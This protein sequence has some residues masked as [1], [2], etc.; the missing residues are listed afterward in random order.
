MRDLFV[1]RDS[2]EGFIMR[3]ALRTLVFIVTSL[4]DEL[5]NSNEGSIANDE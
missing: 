1:M 4:V 3:E 5:A 2:R